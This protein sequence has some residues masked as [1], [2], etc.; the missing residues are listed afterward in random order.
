MLR[1]V[2]YAAQHFLCGENVR[3]ILVNPVT[4]A[5]QNTGICHMNPTDSEFVQ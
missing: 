2:L 5:G 4:A 1:G 3:G